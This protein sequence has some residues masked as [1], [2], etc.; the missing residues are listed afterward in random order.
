MIVLEGS[1]NSRALQIGRYRDQCSRDRASHPCSPSHPV[2]TI[3][4]MAVTH[5]HPITADEFFALPGEL[6]H[7]E[8]VDGE[9]VVDSPSVRHQDIGGWIYHRF[10]TFLDASPGA[11]RA[12]I[13]LTTR[14]DDHNVFVP[15]TWWNVPG[16]ALDPDGRGHR[17]PPDLAVEVRSPGTWRRDRT[18]KKNHDEANGLPELWLVDTVADEIMVHR[19]SSPASPIFDIECTVGEGDVLTTPV[20]PGFALDVTVLFDR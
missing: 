10:M 3:G 11:G 7:T 8:L 17:G 12:G 6:V 5:T 20:I 15:D 4:T 14:L 19:R 1:G 9:I 18:V 13:E 16:H 2:G